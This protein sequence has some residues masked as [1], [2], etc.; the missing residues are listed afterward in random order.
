[1]LGDPLHSSHVVK[2]VAR[3]ERFPIELSRVGVPAT[4]AEASHFCFP[5]TPASPVPKSPTPRATFCSTPEG[6]PSSFQS[7]LPRFIGRLTTYQRQVCS[8]AQLLRYRATLPRVSIR[9]AAVAQTAA[10]D[11]TSSQLPFCPSR[12]IKSVTRC[13]KPLSIRDSNCLRQNYISSR[14]SSWGAAFRKGRTP[15]FN[16]GFVRSVCLINRARIDS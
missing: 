6:F 12:I 1:M 3:L 15:L 8:S 5:K 13:H 9:Q 14:T 2:S 10:I 4:S 7:A 16:L 11:P